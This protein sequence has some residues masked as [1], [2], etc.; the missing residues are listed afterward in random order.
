MFEIKIYDLDPKYKLMSEMIKNNE[1]V[2]TMTF[3]RPKTEEEFNAFVAS[4]DYEGFLYEML[5]DGQPYCEGIVTADS[6]YD[7]LMIN[8]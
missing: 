8:V 4:F 7:D 3:N 6:F 1:P 2:F 5:K